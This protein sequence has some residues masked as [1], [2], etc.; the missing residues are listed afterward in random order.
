MDSDIASFALLGGVAALWG[1]IKTVLDRIRGLF[2][3]QHHLEYSV[4]T[5]VQDYLFTHARLFRW[6]DASVTSMNKFV[7]SQNKRRDVAYE[8]ASISPVVVWYKRRLFCFQTP[9]N[10]QVPGMTA[11]DSLITL[12]YLRGT[13]D[14]DQLIKE[15]LDWENTLATTGQRYKI[16]TVAGSISRPKTSGTSQGSTGGRDEQAAEP[17]AEPRPGMRFLHYKASD[18]GDPQPFD[19]FQ[20]YV[21]CD[22]AAECRADFIRWTKLRDWYQA[23]GIPWRRGHLLHGK[24]GTGKTALIRALAQEVDYPLNVLDLAT[25]DNDGLRWSW[26]RMQRNAPCIIVIEDFDGV[27]NGRVNVLGDKSSLTFDCVLNVIGGLQ[28]ADGV[29]LFI[30]TN[31]PETLDPA[32]GIPGADGA[33]SRP[34]RIDR[35]FALGDPS[36]AVRSAIIQRICSACTEEDLATTRGMSAA[37]TTEYAIGKALHVMWGDNVSIVEQL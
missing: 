4:A 21:L 34:G 15:A 9:Q 27:F 22:T 5:A 12:Y 26:A 1:Q 37:R 23:R 11:S 29:F 19:P 35:C 14:V 18:I 3:Q 10:S 6:G 7:R 24:P 20:S 8:K 33:S 31:H 25:L 30:T 16:V 28:V 13:L 36:D 17:T 32:I 2:V